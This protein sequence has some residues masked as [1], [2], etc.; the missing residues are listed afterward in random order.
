MFYF[1]IIFCNIY[2]GSWGNLI[3]NKRLCCYFVFVVL[4]N[5]TS[6]KWNWYSSRSV[7]IGRSRIVFGCNILT[8]LIKFWIILIYSKFL[9]KRKPRNN[10]KNTPSRQ[11]LFGVLPKNSFRI[12]RWRMHMTQCGFKQQFLTKASFESK[13]KWANNQG[14]ILAIF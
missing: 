9:F 13:E 5:W 3:V 12:C 11:C 1:T 4:L 14:V 10:P 8:F 7:V 6:C 2:P